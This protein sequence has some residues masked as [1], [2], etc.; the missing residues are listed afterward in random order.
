MRNPGC[1]GAFGLLLL[2]VGCG[3]KEPSPV[4]PAPRPVKVIR[5]KEID[6]V[7][8]LLLTGSV[9]SW[10]EQDVAFEVAGRVEFIVES[11]TYVA[12]RWEEEGKVRAEGSVLARI[13]RRT[14]E[15]ARDQA[16]ASVAVAGERLRTATVELKEVLPANQRRAEAQLER[17]QAEWIRTKAAVEKAALPELELI[18]STADRDSRVAELDQAK[19]A[20][21]AKAAE[22]KALEAEVQ[23]ARENLRQAEYDLERCT[24]WAPFSG[25]VSEIKIEAGG[26]AQRGMPVAHLVMMSPIKVDL[27]VSGKTA[28]MLRRGD[29][30]RIYIPGQEEPALGS[31]YEKATVADPET[32]T[33]RISIITRNQRIESPFG[34]E[35]P[36][37]KLPRIE[38][39][40]GLLPLS[41]GTTFAVEA[42]RALRRDDQ[43]FF[44]WANPEY[45]IDSSIPDGT[46]LRLQRHRVVPGDR[47]ANLQGLYLIRELIDVGD[48]PPGTRIPLDVPDTAADE[49]EV[50]IAKPQWSLKPGQLVPVLLAEKAPR[51]GLYVPM[52]V[53]QRI[54]EDRGAIFLA[55]NGRARRVE[56]STT[57]NV[58][59]LFRIEAEGVGPGDE[60]IADYIHFL[61]DGEPVR[62]IRRREFG[63]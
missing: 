7:E 46:V 41:D 47:E 8:P 36:R 12:G 9:E 50:V 59:Q 32:R 62:V 2:F 51:P 4:G 34:P 54:G 16:A 55:E 49:I 21:G 3:G 33:F 37:R 42:N 63:R 38:Q 61:E 24:L 27:A 48:L 43:G 35:D 56:V 15:I 23:T 1:F 22:I 5:L 13:D 58:R 53:I 19:A 45:R 10:K 20:I 11:S 26:F 18:R 39:T 6:P 44:V 17:A 57:E 14:N 60:V 40:L 31:V 28:Q 30:V 29:T 52:N 25:E